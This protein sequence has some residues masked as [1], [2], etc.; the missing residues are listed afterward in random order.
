M[1]ARF[2]CIVANV[3]F[4]QVRSG[5]VQNKRL[6]TPVRKNEKTAEAVSMKIRNKQ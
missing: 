4:T 1:T 2:T 5:F 3:G 6:L